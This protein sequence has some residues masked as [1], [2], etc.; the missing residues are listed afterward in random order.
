MNDREMASGRR[1]SICYSLMQIGFWGMLGAFCGFQTA[2]AMDR[3]FTAGDVGLFIAVQYI[4]GMVSQPLLGR[5]ADRHPEVPLKAVFIC[6]MAPAFLLN[7]AFLFSETRFFGNGVCLFDDGN[8]GDQLL[9]AD[10]LDGDAVYQC[11]GGCS[12]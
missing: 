5:W 4:G 6:L 11:G 2:I 8:F 10:R 12:L 9:P 7:M 1:V 3:G